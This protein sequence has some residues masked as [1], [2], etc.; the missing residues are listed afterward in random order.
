MIQI[1]WVVSGCFALVAV[2]V[3]F[4]LINRHLTSYTNNLE[5][6]YIVRILFMVPLYAVISFASYIFWNHSN[7]LLLV[8]D[9]YES[10]VLTA[11]FYL[12]LAYLSPDP[13]EQKDIFRKVGLSRENDREARK[14]GERPGHWMF[15]LSFVRWKPEDGLYFLQ[16]MKWGVLQYCVIR[17][18]TTL[19]GII[20]DSVGLYCADSWSPGWGH[21]YITVIMSASVTVAMYCLIQLYVPVSGHLAPHK[22]LLKLVAIK[23]VVFLTFWQATFIGFF[24]DFGLI[25]DTPYMTADNIANGISAICETFEMMVFAFVH[26]R[27][28]TYKPYASPRRTPRWRSLAH[29]FNFGE[30]LRELA[31][32][33]RYM[34]NRARGRETDVCARREAVLEN[35]FGRSRL[36]VAGCRVG[37]AGGG[38]SA[39]REKLVVGV[40]K[41]VHVGAERQWLG[42]GDDYAY[43]LEYHMKRQQEKSDGLGEQIEKELTKRGYDRPGTAFCWSAP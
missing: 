35:V 32:G 41:T 15:P 38:E 33:T 37:S 12:L 6:R 2:A 10:T 23:A 17:P 20:L 9:C 8:R 7:I 26:I 34:L 21:I 18:T 42:T 14:R 30:T 5:Q 4:W 27:A 36:D 13:H 1:G 28:F 25:K 11:F 29:A 40:D 19:A 24:E 3:S 22:P 39:A 16:L 31:T 43:G